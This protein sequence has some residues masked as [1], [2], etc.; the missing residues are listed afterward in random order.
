MYNSIAIT[1]LGTI[2]ENYTLIHYFVLIVFYLTLSFISANHILLVQLKLDFYIRF[3]V[4][5][6]LIA[7]EGLSSKKQEFDYHK[8]LNINMHF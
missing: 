3:Y 4:G 5:S 1:T 7:V 8:V 6:G 2:C